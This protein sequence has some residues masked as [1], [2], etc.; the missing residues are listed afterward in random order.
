MRLER[1]SDAGAP[2]GTQE[3]TDPELSSEAVDSSGRELAVGPV[4]DRTGGGSKACLKP[5]EQQYDPNHDQQRRGNIAQTVR[6]KPD[7]M[8]GRCQEQPNADKRDG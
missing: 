6:I 2:Y 1:G 8:A 3:Q 4:P 7:R 5:W